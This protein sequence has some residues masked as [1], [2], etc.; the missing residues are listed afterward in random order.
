MSTQDFA[1]LQLFITGPTFIR[2]EIREAGLLPEFGHRD[3]ENNKR[4][5]PAMAGLKLLAG[6]GD[7]YHVILFNGSGS[8]AMEATVRSLVA[9]DETVLNV[10]VG[11]FGDLYHKMAVVNGKK[12]VQL[13]FEPG[14][15][16]DMAKLEA[17]LTEHK[18]AVVTFTHN[19]TS[20]GVTNDMKAI[21]ALIRKHG[22]MPLVDGVSIFG[23]AKLDLSTSGAATYATSTQKSLALPAGFGILFVNEEAVAKAKTVKNKGFATDIIGQ[24]GRAQKSQTLTTPNTTLANQMAVQIDHIINV[25]GIDNRFARHLKMQAMVHEFVGTLPGFELLAPEGHRSPT[26]TAVRVPA[27]MTVAQLKKVK[28]AMRAKGYL[29]DPGYGKLNTDLEEKGQ[30]VLLRLGHMG[31]V[32]PDM[33]AAYLEAL[34]PE[35]LK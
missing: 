13:K 23:G 18:P 8:N 29:F 19:E 17:A 4:F 33:L 2:P 34:K 3:S 27:G 5:G 35:L 26:V 20:T 24:L 14:Q 9:D 15:A 6:C 21:C 28:E 16:I 25:E 32:T 22:A 10:S 31:D 7:D 12:A 11:A 1:D 30:R